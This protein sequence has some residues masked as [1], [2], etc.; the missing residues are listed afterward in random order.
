MVA[1]GTGLDPIDAYLLLSLTAELRVSE[2]VDA[3]NWVMKSWMSPYDLHPGVAPPTVAP[4]LERRPTPWVSRLLERRRAPALVRASSL[5]APACL[6][7][8][9]AAADVVVIVELCR[10]I[11]DRSGFENRRS[12]HR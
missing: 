5:A 7:G 9:G 2:I 3:P 10:E 12:R 1:R 4:L 8:Q 11:V 6:P